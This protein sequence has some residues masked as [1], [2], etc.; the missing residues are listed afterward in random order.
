MA[1]ETRIPLS[2]TIDMTIRRITASFKEKWLL[3][4]ETGGASAYA[5]AVVYKPGGIYESF[6]FE[7]EKHDFLEI[8]ICVDGTCG[9]QIGNEII[10]IPDG[11][12]CAILPGIIHKEL[13]GQ[14]SY[15]A[16]WMSANM[17]RAVIHLSVKN[18]KRPFTI[19]DM[20]VFKPGLDYIHILDN[21]R[22]ELWKKDNY[23]I[24]AAKAC[25]IKLLTAVCRELKEAST[26]PDRINWKESI[27]SEIVS[28][29]KS[30][31]NTYIRLDEVAHLV[32]ISPNYMNTIFKS[33][34]GKTIIQYHEEYR[35]KMAKSMLNGTGSKISDV[36]LELGF[37]DQY[38]F[39]RIFKKAAGMTPSAYRKLNG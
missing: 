23:Y 36:A 13:P 21:I 29:I 34:T 25:I 31:V 28:Y 32:C 20:H 15:T 16:I 39:S 3:V 19:M 17:S 27:A 26:K 18:E 14:A 12:V 8:C 1:D 37:Y 7:L 2:Q 22:T 10:S 24:E 11:G 38:H 35:I 5:S 4:P 33:V 6:C 30:R 9:I